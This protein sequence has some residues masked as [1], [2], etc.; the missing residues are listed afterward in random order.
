MNSQDSNP[1]APQLRSALLSDDELRLQLL[2][3]G[4]LDHSERSQWLGSIENDSELWRTIAIRFVENQIM[5]ESLTQLAAP[6]SK[7]SRQSNMASSP[8][9]APQSRTQNTKWWL[10]MASS[11]ILGLLLGS[12]LFQT[13]IFSDAN[14]T[15]SEGKKTNS[16]KPSESQS[17]VPDAK[18]F[19]LNSAAQ[20]ND[21]ELRLPLEDALARSIHPVSLNTRRAFLKAGYFVDESSEIANVELPTGSSVKMPV[22]QVK[23][24]FLGSAAYQ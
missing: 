19:N 3:D 17:P 18:Q 20:S 15:L 14:S 24:R 6:H 21:D 10:A 5:D 22:R 23:I 8:V 1:S 7:P 12:L 16:A 4:Q 2:V 9:L 11:L 13:G